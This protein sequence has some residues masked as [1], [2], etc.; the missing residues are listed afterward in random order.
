MHIALNAHLLSFGPTYRGAGISWYI[1]NLIPALRQVDERHTFTVFLGDSRLPAEFA[2]G[3]RFRPVVS[4]FPTVRPAVRILWEQLAQPVLAATDRVDVLHA[5][6]YVQPL[7]CPCR[8]VVTVHDLSFLLFPQYFNRINRLYLSHLTRLSTRRSDRVIAVSE[9]TKRDLVRLIGL[10]PEKIDVVHSAIQAG[11]QPIG[12]A[13]LL[14]DFRRRHGLDDPFILFISTLEPRKNAERLILAYA[15]LRQT[16]RV[17]HKLVLAGAK[18]WRYEGIFARVEELGL[19]KDIIFPGFVPPVDIPLWYN[20]ADLFVYPSLYEGFGSPPLESMACGTPVV[21]S[22][23]SSL[24]EVVGDAALLVEP[25]DV[26]ALADAIWRILSDPS[27]RAELVQ[28]GLRRVRQFSWEETARRTV[29]VYE[30]TIGQSNERSKD[31][32]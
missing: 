22:S 31:W 14:R 13:A 20:C 12:D 30:N 27:L 29:Q 10:P 3:P 21:A 6:G 16:G 5:L 32:R 8:S 7:A 4:R 28:K 2:P 25:T 17:S 18:G 1:R 11:F 24:P 23:G 19:G 26:N 9:S 15:R